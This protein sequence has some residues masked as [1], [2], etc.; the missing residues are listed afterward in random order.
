MCNINIIMRKHLDYKENWLLGFLQSVTACSYNSNSDGEGMYIRDIVI[1]NINKINYFNYRDRIKDSP[2]IITH[3]RMSTSGFSAEYT[4]PFYNKDFVLV[5]NGIMYEYAEGNK[6][7]TFVFFSRLM[8]TY[9]IMKGSREERLIGAIKLL[10][11][12]KS[13]G[14]Y[15]IAIYDR[16]TELLYYFKNSSTSMYAIRDNSLLYLTT[17]QGNIKFF[18]LPTTVQQNIKSYQIYRIDKK[19]QFKKVGRIAH[20]ETWKNLVVREKATADYQNYWNGYW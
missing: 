15:S 7:D 3:Q 13:P 20:Q 5:H 19:L 4:H 6:S 18:D 9:K 17:N 11:D 2:L 10:L 16:K 12:N 8:Q 14:S 1:K